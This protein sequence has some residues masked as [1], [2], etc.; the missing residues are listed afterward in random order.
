[1]PLCLLK[2]NSYRF[3]LKNYELSGPPCVL[4]LIASFKKAQ[5]NTDPMLSKLSADYRGLNLLG[6]A[7]SIDST[8]GF[9]SDWQTRAESENGCYEFD[10]Q[11]VLDLAHIDGLC[12]LVDAGP[13]DIG[14][15]FRYVMA[16]LKA[17]HLQERTTRYSKS[18]AE[19]FRPYEIE[20][21]IIA[22]WFCAS[23]RIPGSFRTHPIAPS[24]SDFYR[25]KLMGQDRLPS[26]YP[27][28]A[29]RELAFRRG[30]RMW[31][32]GQITLYNAIGARLGMYDESFE[33]FTAEVPMIVNNLWSR[34]VPE[35]ALALSL[36]DQTI[37]L[38]DRVPVSS[39]RSRH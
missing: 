5:A 31:A 6:I 37:H 14:H 36:S 38:E 32:A 28:P 2:R 16:H 1:M 35:D 39:G 25:L 17:H 23:A 20:A 30:G 24:F 27:W 11:I 33:E 29:E 10:G 13:G 3:S 4:V 7:N 12:Q 19:D 18:Y 22:G 15:V 21:D 26:S 9:P 8:F 34:P